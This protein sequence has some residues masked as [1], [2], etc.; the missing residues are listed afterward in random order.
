MTIQAG[1][2]GAQW[3]E[4]W[5]GRHAP[6]SDH[7]RDARVKEA[8]MLVVQSLLNTGIPVSLRYPRDIANFFQNIPLIGWHN[9]A[10]LAQGPQG[11][12][13]GTFDK[14]SKL[15]PD[16]ALQAAQHFARTAIPNVRGGE[17]CEDAGKPPRVEWLLEFIR[18]YRLCYLNVEYPGNIRGFFD[19]PTWGPQLRDALEQNYE[20]CCRGA[21]C[22]APLMDPMAG[23]D[24]HRFGAHPHQPQ[25]PLMTSNGDPGAP[26]VAPEAKASKRLSRTSTL[27][28]L[29]RSQN[30]VKKVLGAF[31]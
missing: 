26:A 29:Y 10:V 22:M 7:G 19:D 17:S 21:F 24:P 15:W 23:P 31:T 30:L 20:A 4:W 27:R 16:N 8:K 12:D 13:A 2:L 5:G 9:D 14:G 18:E 1:F 6:D 11:A 25:H 28:K 3:G